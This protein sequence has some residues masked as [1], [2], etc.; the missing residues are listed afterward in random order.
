MQLLCSMCGPNTTVTN[1][2]IWN[3]CTRCMNDHFIIRLKHVSF[4]NQNRSVCSSCIICLYI[5]S[6]KKNSKKYIKIQN[7]TT[8]KVLKIWKFLP[9]FWYKSFPLLLSSQVV[10]TELSVCRYE[11]VSVCHILCNIRNYVTV[12][13]RLKKSQ[14]LGICN[15]YS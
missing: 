11:T 13:K 8:P 15:S 6:W 10:R 5:T 12:Y 9:N 2:S 3:L 4:A 7:L 1:V 14:G